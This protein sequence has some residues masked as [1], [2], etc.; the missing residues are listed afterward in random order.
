M[1][2]SNRALGPVCKQ[3]IRLLDLSIVRGL[4]IVLLAR[5]ELERAN[6]EKRLKSGVSFLV[7]VQNRRE[8]RQLGRRGR[9]A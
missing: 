8:F 4:G 2:K 6:R 7:R 5:V 3:P 9:D 1:G